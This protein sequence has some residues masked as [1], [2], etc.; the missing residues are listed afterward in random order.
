MVQTFRIMIM[1]ELKPTTIFIYELGF[2]ITYTTNEKWLIIDNNYAKKAANFAF[3]FLFT[4][5]FVGKPI[6]H[7]RQEFTQFFLIYLPRIVLIKAGKS[8]SYNFFWICSLQPLSEEG[9]EHGKVDRSRS[10]VHHRLQISVI[11]VLA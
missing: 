2:Y 8:I 9:E 10:F 11:W 1:L 6:A 3:V 4:Y 5:F 7:R